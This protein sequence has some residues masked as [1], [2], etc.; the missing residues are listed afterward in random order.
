MDVAQL[1][2][3][4]YPETVEA[5]NQAYEDVKAGRTRPIAGFLEELREKLGL[6]R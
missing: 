6:P 4:N 5:V 3:D 1:D 2:D